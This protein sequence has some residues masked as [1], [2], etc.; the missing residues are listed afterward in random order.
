MDFHAYSK[1]QFARSDFDASGYHFAEEEGRFKAVV[2]CKRWGKKKLLT[3][4]TLENG[5]KLLSASFQRDGFL[6]L[7][8]IPEGASV[9]LVYHRANTGICYLK[10]VICEE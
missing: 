5:E 9:E 10:E 3:Y 2:D 4:F 1:Q 8:D 6:G 7:K